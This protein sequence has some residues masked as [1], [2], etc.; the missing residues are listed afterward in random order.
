MM[1][2]RPSVRLLQGDAVEVL[3]GLPAESV[4]TCVT[5]PPYYGLRD[6]GAAG[7]YGL[8]ATVEEYV[9]RMVEVF[10]E[11]RRVLRP[12][13]TLWLNLGDSYAGGGCGARDEERWPKQ[14]RNDH[15]ATHAKTHTGLKPKDLIGVPWRVA[16]A[17]QADGWWL[18]SDIVWAKPNPM[19]ESVTDRPTKAHEYLFLLAK[20]E[21]YFYDADAIREPHTYG[22]HARHTHGDYI[23]PGQPAHRNLHLAGDG[24]G[25]AGATAR[26]WPAGWA[27]GADHSAVGHNTPERRGKTA[28]APHAGGR[29]Q[30]PEPGEPNAF[31]ALGRNARTVWTIATQPF[32]GAHFA[33]FPEA[34]VQRC[35]LAGAPEGATVLDPFVGSGT[36]AMVAARLGR[37]A[38]GIDLNDSYIRMAEARVR[39]YTAQT[40]LNLAEVVF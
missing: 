28:R 14:S 36:T 9:A 10:V 7:Q 16:F 13:G 18:R 11:V 6:Y 26:P 2:T 34:L 25:A 35:V 32:P 38:I 27:T 8:E 30:A 20:S 12:D 23:A 21:R 1:L 22:D 15:M 5:S 24:Y 19:P 37:N 39:P 40:K 17:L 4:Q 31:H 3:R 29:R 33:T